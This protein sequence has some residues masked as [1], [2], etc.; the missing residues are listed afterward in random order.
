ME[1]AVE[2]VGSCGGGFVPV[3]TLRVGERGVGRREGWKERGEGGRE[4]GRGR[5]RRDG[6][7]KER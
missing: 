1:V 4:G 6:W 5:G 3:S 7:G 2:R